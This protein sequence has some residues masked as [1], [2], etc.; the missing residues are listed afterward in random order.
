MIY[1]TYT[2]CY[3]MLRMRILFYVMSQ[4]NLIVTGYNEMAACRHWCFVWFGIPLEVCNRVLEA[5]GVLHVP[6]LKASSMT[7]ESFVNTEVNMIVSSHMDLQ[8]SKSK[9]SGDL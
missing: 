5:L 8:G 6:Q 7:G 2:V 9:V 1:S 3:D 4:D